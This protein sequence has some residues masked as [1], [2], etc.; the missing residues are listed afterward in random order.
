MES[1]K[2]MFGRVR[3]SRSELYSNI[4]VFDKFKDP[5]TIDRI[6]LILGYLSDYDI[7]DH[8]SVSNRNNPKYEYSYTNAIEYL[9]KVIKCVLGDRSDEKHDGD[10]V[11]IPGP[12]CLCEVE[13]L[14]YGGDILLQEWKKLKNIDDINIENTKELIKYVLLHQLLYSRQI[15]YSGK[16]F[17]KPFYPDE[18]F[19]SYNDDDILDING[20]ISIYDKHK[21]KIK[22]VENM[23][24]RI[25]D[26]IM[27]YEQ[28]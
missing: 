4:N 8:K 6:I 27:Y 18:N 13:D 17:T 12:C 24:N 20:L 28:N 15:L 3:K 23:T 21:N 5:N 26:E 22:N 2:K 14:Y 9:L 19:F 16:L 1:I 10:C 25:I 7:L 11:L